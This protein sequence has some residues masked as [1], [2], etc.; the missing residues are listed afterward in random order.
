MLISLI[1]LSPMMMPINKVFSYLM[2]YIRF[3]FM[4]TFNNIL[5]LFG[6]VRVYDIQNGADLT[7]MYYL[8]KNVNRLGPGIGIDITYPKLGV[9]RYVDNRYTRYICYDSKLLEI[10]HV[11]TYLSAKNYHD[12]KKIEIVRRSKSTDN[13]VSEIDVTKAKINFFD[14]N[15]FAEIPKREQKNIQDQKQGPDTVISSG[16]ILEDTNKTPMRFTEVF[17]IIKFYQTVNYPQGIVDVNPE[18]DRTIRIT[19]EKF[20][21]ELLEFITTH[22][23]LQLK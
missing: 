20:D 3:I 9:C 17:D 15:H 6:Y 21:D 10:D 2:M 18:E 11:S 8:L 19:R 23:E 13:V 5:R 1:K 22:E 7:I 12:I 4:C 14:S 16:V